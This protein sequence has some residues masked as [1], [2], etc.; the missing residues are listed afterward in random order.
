M[1]GFLEERVFAP[2]GVFAKVPAVVAPKHNDGI[3]A[4]LKAV[5]T[6]QQPP[7]QG[8]GIGDTTCIVLAHLKGKL[9]VGVG[10]AF[11]A[12]VF[13]ELAR[14]VPRGLSLGSGR[15]RRGGERGVGVRLHVLGRR[16]KRQV[17]ADDAHGEKERFVGLGQ[18]IHLLQGLVGNQPVGIH[19]VRSVEGLIHVHVLRVLANLTIGQSVHRAARMLPRTGWQQVACPS[20]RH[21]RFVILI[22]ISPAATAGM[23]RDFPNRHRRVAMLAKPSWKTRVFNLGEV[24]KKRPIVRG[25]ITPCE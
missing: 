19:R 23:M 6:L 4:Q 11:P 17:R 15:M 18:R 24:L 21:F 7:H 22:P 10:V 8:V 1:E 12:I 2:N 13:H 14:A 5:Q 25:P 16:T 9:R 3:V 20:T